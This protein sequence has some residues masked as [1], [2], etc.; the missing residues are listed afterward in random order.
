MRI[1][2]VTPTYNNS[3][4]LRATIESV[5]AQTWR[6]IE[7]VIVDGAS[8]MPTLDIIREYDSRYPRLIKWL[9]EPD[10]GV[11]DALNKG[12]SIATGDIIGTLH[13]GDFYVSN[14]IIERV[15]KEFDSDTD[16]EPPYIYGDVHFYDSHGRCRRLYS[17]SPRL[18]A[19]ILSGVAPPHPSLFI[20]RGTLLDMGGYDASFRVAADYELFVRMALVNDIIGRYIPLDMVAMSLGGISTRLVNRLFANNIE[21]MRALRVNGISSTGIG[22]FRRYL[23]NPI[24]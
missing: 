7:M 19:D 15:A 3:E 4:A 6:D 14:H 11:Y 16:C 24:Q 22:V 20:R 23:F 13:G 2:V 1:S 9:S 18:K 5:V 17:G 21:K 10:D 12:L 8:D